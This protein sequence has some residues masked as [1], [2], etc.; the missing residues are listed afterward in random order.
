[1]P[2]RFCLYRNGDLC[3]VPHPLDARGR[4][5]LQH[6]PARHPSVLTFLNPGGVAIDVGANLG[7]WALPL[8]RRVGPS[9]RVL[10]IEPAPRHRGRRRRSE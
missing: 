10:A 9:G 6:S 2:R 1:M 7:E 8:A 3:C 5:A 4:H